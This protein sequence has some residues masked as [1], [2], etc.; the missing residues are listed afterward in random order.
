MILHYFL[1][2]NRSGGLNR[3]ATDL[4]VTQQEADEQVS[5]LFPSGSIM[6]RKNAVI[7]RVKDYHGIRSYELLGGNP[8][9]L[10]EG[11]RDPNMILD[12]KH[13][14]S[15]ND[16]VSFCKEVNPDILHIHTWMGFPE[17]ILPRLKQQKCKIIFSAHDYFGICPKVNLIKPDGSLCLSVSNEECSKC[18]MG[19]PSEKY[20]RLRNLGCL[21][22][23]KKILNPLNKLRMSLHKSQSQIEKTFCVHDYL[24]LQHHYHGLLKQ[25][26]RI[27]FNSEVTQKNYLRYF[28]DL[29]GDIYPIT[30]RD[31]IDRRRNKI[32]DETCIHM[33]F[34]GSLA[35]YKG[36][37]LLKSVLKELKSNQITN[38]HLDVWGNN[39]VGTDSQLSE[40]TYHGYFSAQEEY[41]VFQNVDLLI[42]P[43]IC[44]ETFGFVV[45]EALSCG[46][47]VLCSKN[48][49]AKC[50]VSPEMIFYSD[51]ELKAKLCNL[52]ENKE[53][54]FL[55]RNEII[56]S[57]TSILSADEH[58]HIIK[59]N[60]YA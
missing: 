14:L 36:F 58:W 9:P 54:L 46:V 41:Q 60:L 2:I 12:Q 40:I 16:V 11:I 1:G 21:F 3:Y 25:C 55:I 53:E 8:I 24:S 13:R 26:D 51:Q 22:K 37:P 45:A 7:R 57:S 47:P 50:L 19:A 20:L 38:W 17:E 10:L 35:P 28:P 34:I 6:L 5:V 4:A 56:H 18:N 29:T 33:C 27:H 15:E 52:L 39:T 30:H 44:F 32:V 31:I 59:N 42:V 43:S 23:F 48:V 49:G